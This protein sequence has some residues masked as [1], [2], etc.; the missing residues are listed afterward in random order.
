[1]GGGVGT[2]AKTA[3]RRMPPMMTA[4]KREDLRRMGYLPDMISQTGWFANRGE[5]IFQKLVD[6]KPVKVVKD[7]CPESSE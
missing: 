1:M 6:K 4:A 3:G 2:P 5:K 7:D